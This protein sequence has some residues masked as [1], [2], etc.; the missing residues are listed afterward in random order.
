MLAN[1][2]ISGQDTTWL[3]WGKAKANAQRAYAYQITN[4]ASEVLEYDLH[5][6]KVAVT[7]YGHSV[8]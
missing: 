5:K 1:C 3:E 2:P 4:I 6:R 7:K 8:G